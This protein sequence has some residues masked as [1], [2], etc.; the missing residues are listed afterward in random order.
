MGKWTDRLML[1]AGRKPK[2]PH[3]DT[4]DFA[5]LVGFGG[6]NLSRDKPIPKPTFPNLRALSKTPYARRAINTIK[7]PIANLQW[8]IVPIDS[9]QGENAELQRQCETVKKCLMTPNNVD[10]FRSLIEAVLED[11]LV[12]GAGVIEQQLGG[13]QTRP[14]WM[15]PVDAQSISIFPFW[16]GDPA[17]ARY[18]QTTGY[19]DLQDNQVKKLLRDDEIIYVK[20]NPTTATP[21]GFSPMEIAFTSIS[22]QLNVGE[23]AGNVASNAQ[24]QNLIYAGD[25]TEDAILTFRAY[26]RNEIEGQGQTPIIAGTNS[27]AVLPLHGGTDD[28]L[29]L[30]YQQFLIREIAN[31]FDL[32]PQNMALEADVNR[33]TS[34]TAEDRDWDHAIIPMAR[35]LE[36]YLTRYA[37]H[38]RL[39]YYQIQ[40]KFT[41]LDREDE[42]ATA[43]IY[44]KYYRNNLLTPNE[45]RE[46]LGLPPCKNKWAELLYN[47]AQEAIAEARGQKSLQ[48]EG[49]QAKQ[50]KSRS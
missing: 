21:Y 33:N 41:G 17:E 47:D 15:W 26:W 32:S 49:A 39:G 10:S 43:D 23:F 22:R 38:A 18:C 44:E 16:S 29:Y 3:R 42:K 48:S 25:T 5:R 11:I 46:R 50:E 36:S 14:L 1:W 37:I 27:P 4:L 12:I 19:T 6:M 8:E 31:A 45:W 2:M 20:P 35:L 28:A 30:A 7:N 40:F 24:P 9:S 13:D 34:E